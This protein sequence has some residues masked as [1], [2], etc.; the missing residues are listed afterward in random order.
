MPIRV[1]DERT[2]EPGAA[3]L[4]VRIH[5]KDADELVALVRQSKS[6]RRWDKALRQG[7][8][9]IRLALAKEA[10]VMCSVAVEAG[11]KTDKFFKTILAGNDFDQCYLQ[12]FIV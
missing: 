11:S 5:T 2:E 7:G 4:R 3:D 1:L 8:A 9:N 10:D 12:A 6:L